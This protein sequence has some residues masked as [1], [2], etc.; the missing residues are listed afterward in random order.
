MQS[1]YLAL[2]D[3][4]VP[5]TDDQKRRLGLATAMLLVTWPLWLHRRVELVAFEDHDVIRRSNSLDFTFPTRV[6][7]L[8]EVDG[9]DTANIAV[10]LAFFRKGTLVHFS[11]SAEGS[12]TVPMLSTPQLSVLAE[13]ALLVTAEIALSTTVPQ[14][15]AADITHVVR[16]KARF[17]PQVSNF[18]G[19]AMD[20]RRR[21]LL[22]TTAVEDDIAARTILSND[23]V[24]PSLVKAFSTQ[25]MAA[26]LLPVT[27]D[28]RR[29]VHFAYDERFYDVTDGLLRGFRTFLRLVTGNR[30]RRVLILAPNASDSASYHFEAEAPEG[31]QVSSRRAYIESA[32]MEVEERRTSFQRIHLHY[33]KLPRGSTLSV[34]LRLWPRS[35]TIVRAGTLAAILTV[36]GVGYVFYRITEHADQS[37]Q[38]A[39]AIL[40]VVPTLLSLYLV[41]S[42]EHPMTTHL[43]W[44][45]RIIA[46]APGVLSF[47]AAGVMVG[48]FSKRL[49]LFALGTVIALL[50]AGTSILGQTWWRAARREHRR[51]SRLS[52]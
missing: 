23:E 33:S 41:R 50:L 39:A 36:L 1:P 3:Q 8:L 29:V 5:L 51:E 14:S 35:S 38:D 34:V 40:L 21:L 13:A 17:D 44:P 16:D 52:Q 11:L 18:V 48:G 15:V 37:V 47:V 26:V 43:L 19:S 32:E 20:A 6:L 28:S 46:T 7:H 45:L 10:P 22:K 4:T 9:S 42:N 49:S 27:A 2:Y 31:L 12:A 30:A 24:F 25:F